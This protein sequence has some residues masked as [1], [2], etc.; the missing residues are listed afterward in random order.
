M[1]PKRIVPIPGRPL[2][3]SAAGLGLTA[4]VCLL[5]TGVMLADEG[6][7][8]L[9]D[10]RTAL[11]EW[12]ETRRILSQEKRDWTLDRETLT[13]RI[14]ILKREVESLRARI[15]GTRSSIAETERK[16]AELAAENDGLKEASAD[17]LGTVSVLEGR[18]RQLLVRLP[19]PIRESVKS[20]S[21]RIPE[22]PQPG[23]DSLGD[24]FQNVIGI[25]NEVNKF[26]REITV[27][28]EVRTLPDGTAAQVEVLYVGIAQAYFAGAQ[29]N[30]GG[31]G[32]PSPDGW[33]W[34]PADDFAPQIA[35]AIAMVK[36]ERVAGFVRLPLRIE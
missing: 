6:A 31:I 1:D 15:G 3:A 11:E 29:G 20:L 27:T 25:L 35:Q 32:T 34:T 14:E 30:V 2:R 18:T 5:P 9:S 8:I 13:D 10:T 21:Q 12:V 26:N 36:N 22:D 28:S 4:A 16:R 7:G 17:L 33:T 23:E 19:D 24:R